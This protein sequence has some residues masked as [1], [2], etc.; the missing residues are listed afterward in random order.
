MA[1]GLSVSWLPLTHLVG[2]AKPAACPS[3][4]QSL[5]ATSRDWRVDD[6]NWMFK[7]SIVVLGC[8]AAL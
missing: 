7:L 1:Y 4:A 3:L 8:S 2:G 6:V 5:V